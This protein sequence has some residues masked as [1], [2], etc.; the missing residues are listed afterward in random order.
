MKRDTVVASTRISKSGTGVSQERVDMVA[1]KLGI[2][3]EDGSPNRSRLVRRALDEFLERHPI[4]LIEE[5]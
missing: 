3:N 1:M 2:V 4:P 5:P